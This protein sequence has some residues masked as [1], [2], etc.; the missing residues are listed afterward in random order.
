MF[1]GLNINTNRAQMTSAV[2]EG[3]AFSLM[4]CLEECNELGL[5]SSRLIASGGGARSYAW[6]QIQADIFNI[7]LTVTTMEEQSCLGAAI[8]AG[9]GIGIY[10]SIEEGCRQVVKYQNTVYIPNPKHHKIY[11]E[12]YQLFKDTYKASKYVLQDA[13]NLATYNKIMQED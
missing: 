7:P 3:V 8:T 12:Y 2:M 10:K 13:R 1:L 6:L 9:T 11:M 4:Q 5:K